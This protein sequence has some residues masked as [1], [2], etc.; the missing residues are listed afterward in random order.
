MEAGAGK[1]M[2]TVMKTA[3]AVV[4]KMKTDAAAAAAAA[5]A[6]LLRWTLKSKEKL[7]AWV[8]V[9]HIV[10]AALTNGIREKPGA[11]HKAAGKTKFISR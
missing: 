4:M 8:A 3:E 10:Q 2:T 1:I 5:N 11:Q 7:Q 6:D 9:Q